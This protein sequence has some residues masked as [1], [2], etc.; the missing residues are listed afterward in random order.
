[1]RKNLI[2]V[3]KKFFMNLSGQEPKGDSLVDVIDNAAEN[4]Q[5]GSGGGSGS[6]VFLVNFHWEE[7]TDDDLPLPIGSGELPPGT[8]INDGLGKS[9][10]VTEKVLIADKTISEIIAAHHA[11]K[12]IRGCLTETESYDSGS[13]EEETPPVEEEDLGKSATR[14]ITEESFDD[15]SFQQTYQYALQVTEVQC[16]S[17]YTQIPYSETMEEIYMGMDLSQLYL[18]NITFTAI[19][20]SLNNDWSDYKLLISGRQQY[21][22]PLEPPEDM[23]AFYIALT[24]GQYKKD[25]WEVGMTE[26]ISIP[27]VSSSQLLPSVTQSDSGKFLKVSS[28]GSWQA[29]TYNALPSVTSDSKDKVLAVNSSGVW[30]TATPPAKKIVE[31]SSYESNTDSFTTATA[32]T[33]DSNIDFYRKNPGLIIVTSPISDGG[34]S[35]QY[36]IDTLE[37]KYS[38]QYHYERIYG[39]FWRQIT[40]NNQPVTQRVEVKLCDY[41]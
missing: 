24:Q 27:E 25:Y 41:N 35:Q 28:G 18:Y 32:K 39:Y 30:T 21:E 9:K 16:I 31:I 6:D 3:L 14:G 34:Y 12:I 5:G 7:S 8:G 11:N 37:Y 13:H 40:V 38:S 33:I 20:L 15:S 22:F 29:E 4:V 26:P 17:G 36:I 2:N 10:G 19:D 23:E 1:M